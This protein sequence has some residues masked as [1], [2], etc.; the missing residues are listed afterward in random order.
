MK[1]EKKIEMVSLTSSIFIFSSF[2]ATLH[3]PSFPF[4]HIHPHRKTMSIRKLN[5]LNPSHSNTLPTSGPTAVCAAPKA[6]PNVKK[7]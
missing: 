4:R 5:E 7:S 1:T 2:D 6:P 3:K